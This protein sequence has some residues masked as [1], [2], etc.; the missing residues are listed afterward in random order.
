M[1]NRKKEKR[2]R[3]RRIWG[4]RV[5]QAYIE[6]CLARGEYRGKRSRRRSFSGTYPLP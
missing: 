3:I 2:R 1:K 6:Y 5:G 4:R